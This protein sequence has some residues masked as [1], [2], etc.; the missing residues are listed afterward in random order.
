MRNLAIFVFIFIFL[1]IYTPMFRA[2]V[3]AEDSKPE[4][5]DTSHKRSFY[6]T[7]RLQELFETNVGLEKGIGIFSDLYK[8][9][10]MSMYWYP[11]RHYIRPD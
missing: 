11:K 5:A 7:K 9:N 4:T 1:F 6:P 2:V 3:K 8:P 10:K